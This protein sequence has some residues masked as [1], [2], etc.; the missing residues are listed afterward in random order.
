LLFRLFEVGERYTDIEGGAEYHRA[1]IAAFSALDNTIQREYI[2]KVFEYFGTELEDVNVEKWRKAAG[3][4]IVT[5]IKSHLTKEEIETSE[6]IFG[7]VPEGQKLEPHPGAS[8]GE[9]GFV[10][11]RSPV[12][13]ADFS[14]EQIIEHL[15]TDWS[16]SLLKKQYGA[17]DFLS[18]RGAEGL[19]DALKD[20]IKRRLDAY[21][22]KINDFF[23][24]DHIAAHY[25]YSMIRGIEE[26]LRNKEQI[27][28]EQA[29]K[30]IDFFEVIKKIL[31]RKT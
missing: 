5:Y 25:V 16:P 17:D 15:K 27:S 10:A 20:D 24:R 11:H 19:G 31:F 28:L 8:M 4:E 7:K 26:M 14:I 9:A 6:K 18:P 21:L 23:D 29:S 1:L 22:E 12:N 30:I 3:L 2:A 13:V